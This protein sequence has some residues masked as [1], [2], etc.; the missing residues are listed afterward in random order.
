MTKSMNHTDTVLNQKEENMASNETV[1]A[2]DVRESKARNEKN[3]IAN[4][5]EELEDARKRR[6][7]DEPS[8][9]TQE[10][11]EVIRRAAGLQVHAETAEVISIHSLDCFG[12][13]DGKGEVSRDYFVRNPGSDEWVPLSYLPEAIQDALTDKHDLFNE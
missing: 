13:D 7:E 11:W 2:S 3:V 10:Q 6:G 12:R 9:I 1:T 8:E 5:L 4:L